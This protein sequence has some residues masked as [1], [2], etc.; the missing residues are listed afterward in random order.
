MDTEFIQEDEKIVEEEIITHGKLYFSYNKEES[1]KAGDHRWAHCHFTALGTGKAGHSLDIINQD[2]I[3]VEK[4]VS[5]SE[6][7]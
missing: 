6:I 1:L 2:T 4:A 3:W 5:D 7:S